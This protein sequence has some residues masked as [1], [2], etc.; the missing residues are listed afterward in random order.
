MMVWNSMPP[1]FAT[2]ASDFIAPAR[3]A[4]FGY[5]FQN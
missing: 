4:L 3:S 1:F 5:F 2:L